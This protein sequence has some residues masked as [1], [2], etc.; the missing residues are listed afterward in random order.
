MDTSEQRYLSEATGWER[1][2]YDDIQVTFRAPIVNWIW[3]T[4]TANEP[5]FTRYL[6]GQVK[7]AFQ[8]EAF[9]AFSF[10]YRDAVISAVEESDHEIPAYRREH[11]DIQAG[12]YATLRSQLETFDVVIPRLAVLFEV[13]DRSL[14]GEQVGGSPEPGEFATAP[15]PEWVDRDRGTEPS[16]AA[17]DALPEDAEDTVEAVQAFHELDEG[18]PSIYRCLLQWPDTFTTMWNDL[19]A[20]LESAAF[21]D[22]RDDVGSLA[23]D[24]VD[25]MAYSPRLTP[26]DLRARGFDDDTIDGLADLF[27]EFNRGSIETVLPVIPLLAESLDVAGR[28]TAAPSWDAHS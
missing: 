18:L 19:E 23:G 12:E 7:P 6:W 1:G 9:G 3:R 5:E 11:F 28:R 21:D 4:L 13:A 14:Q 22:A 17:F 8:T 15:L 27:A 20:T 25:A 26:D 10:A 2:L 16:M 24:Y